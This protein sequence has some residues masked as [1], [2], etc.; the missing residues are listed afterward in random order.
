M[1]VTGHGALDIDCM[2][3]NTARIGLRGNGDINLTG[4]TTDAVLSISGGV[5]RG[6]IDGDP[7]FYGTR[8]WAGAGPGGG[9]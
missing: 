6:D 2:I 4:E 3:V 9:R 5:A 1:P 8:S 7:V